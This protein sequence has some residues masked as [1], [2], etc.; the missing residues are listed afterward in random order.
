MKGFS[1]LLMIGSCGSVP[2]S[3]KLHSDLR[4]LWCHVDF[5]GNSD[6][7]IREPQTR[8]YVKSE[9]TENLKA[10]DLDQQETAKTEAEFVHVLYK[11]MLK[12]C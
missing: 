6:I 1:D 10:E 7:W 4:V 3:L 8:F 2:V 9:R 11:H 5:A 12:A